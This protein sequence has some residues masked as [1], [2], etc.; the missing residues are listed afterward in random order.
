MRLPF[1]GKKPISYEEA[2][3]R[4]QRPDA[5]A[6]RDVARRLDTRPEI[7]YYLAEDPSPEVRRDIAANPSTPGQANLLLASDT[8]G[9]V[10]VEL[11][12]KVSRL[13]PNLSHEEADQVSSLA[14]QAIEILARDQLSKVRAV[15]AEEIKHAHN[16]P[17]HL[18]VQLAHDLEALVS[19]PVLEYSPLL[20]DN[21]LLEIIGTN[22]GTTTGA[23]SLSAIARRSGLS[24]ELSDAIAESRSEPAVAALLANKSAQIREE[25]LD[26]IAENAAGIESWYEPLAVRPELSLRAMRRIAGFVATSVIGLLAER[27]DLDETTAAE[28]RQSV[29]DRLKDSDHEQ[30]SSAADRA[31]AMFAAGKLDDETIMAALERNDRPFVTYGLAYLA[32]VPRS[33]VTAIV[34]A[35]S[36][37]GLTA[38]CWKAGLSMR[39]AM[40]LQVKLAGIKPNDILNARHGTDYPLSPAE[41]EQQLSFFTG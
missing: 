6:R 41:L 17:K 8:D 24:G 5:K 1:F 34:E 38:L 40:R 36:A 26:L 4:M 35:R 28:L 23:G 7:L 31:K 14:M 21:D 39:S 15:I 32:Q 12:R 18:V 25:T 11:A 19:A 37:R 22:A 9:E 30:S 27:H 29:R 16:V 33:V 10:R 20:A 13:L 2:K 3:E